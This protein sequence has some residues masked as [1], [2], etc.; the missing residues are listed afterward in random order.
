LVNATVGEVT[1]TRVMQIKKG[2]FSR[3]K[4]TI[5][6]KIGLRK[7]RLVDND[8]VAFGSTY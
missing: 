8:G 4:M 6:K 1:I 7:V 5:S 2:G 3:R